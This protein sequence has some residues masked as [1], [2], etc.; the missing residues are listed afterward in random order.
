MRVCQDETESSLRNCSYE[1]SAVCHISFFKLKAS[2]RK[3][4]YRM[5]LINPWPTCA[6][7]KAGLSVVVART[8]A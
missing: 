8:H 5:F 4:E 6:H 3:Y 2:E 7:T 1:S